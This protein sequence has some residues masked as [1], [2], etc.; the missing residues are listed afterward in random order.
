MSATPIGAQAPIQPA[1]NYEP[2]PAGHHAA[3]RRV[4]I[5]L[6]GRGLALQPGNPWGMA[7]DIAEALGLR[8]VPDHPGRGRTDPTGR[9]SRKGAHR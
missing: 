3:T 1:I 6:I 4:A 2:S 8:E 5:A 9:R 7:H